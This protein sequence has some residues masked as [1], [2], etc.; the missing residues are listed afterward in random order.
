[1]EPRPRAF[2]RFFSDRLVRRAG[3]LGTATAFGHM[4]LL[5]LTPLLSRLYTPE[6]F[7]IFGI[8]MA[9]ATVFNALAF[10]RLE[11]S[12]PVCRTHELAAAF[13]AFAV[14]GGCSLAVAT[15]AV[16]AATLLFSG[17][18]GELR[19]VL[20]IL[21]P[22]LAAI[23]PLLP[24]S[25]LLLRSGDFT[26]YAV[27]TASR[28]LAPGVGQLL[29][30]LAGGGGRGLVLGYAA[31]SLFAAGIAWTRVRPALPGRWG[32]IRLRAARLYFERYR[33][34]PLFVA[35]GAL[36]HAAAQY[37][38]VVLLAALYDLSLAGLYG[39]AQRLLGAP[40][41]LVAQAVSQ[42]LF[43][44]LARKEHADPL[45]RV[46]RL[47]GPLTTAGAVVLLL[48]LLPGDVGW[49]LILGDGWQGFHTMLA[50]LT[51]AFLVRFV[52]E[53]LWNVLVVGDQRA[54]LAANLLQLVLTVVVYVVVHEAGGSACL[55]V[56]LY[57]LATFVLGVAVL[58]VI[59]RTARR[60][61]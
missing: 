33:D 8:F 19:D 26:G 14:L 49:R 42:A 13:S 43:S 4:G 51:P 18:S 34:R 9:A 61:A 56:G 60:L 40:I 17:L 58:A 55:A 45:Q 59:R 50:L 5:L 36:A 21:P 52:V 25:A 3:L 38:P 15:A 31:G 23:M 30:G 2:E 35:P 29:F 12:L 24:L 22:A 20:W 28:V 57:S 54:F 48:P 27:V 47:L 32:A 6:E 44:E 37:L 39:L 46:D 16:W 10:L 53:S 11:T 41:R 1:M 7:G